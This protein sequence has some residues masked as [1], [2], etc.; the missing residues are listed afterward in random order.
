MLKRTVPLSA[1]LLAVALL[2][3]PPLI[4]SKTSAIPQR[5]HARIGGFMGYTYYVELQDGGLQ[6]TRSGGGQKTMSARV[7]P[8][9][10]QW[11]EF[12]RELDALGIWRWRAHYTN[13]GVADGT[14]WSLDVA[15]PDRAIKTEGDND[16]PGATA[17]PSGVPSGSKVF[18][19]YLK[20]VQQ[21]L[22]GRAFE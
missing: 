8:T 2:C 11:T 18:A 4:A 3:S 7:R 21:L 13:P 17:N 10:E 16:Y 22:G 15:Y 9:T 20:A 19:R 14:Q 6:Y 1:L 5:F 12:R